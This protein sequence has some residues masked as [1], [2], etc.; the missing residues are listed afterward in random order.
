[1]PTALTVGLLAGIVTALAAYGLGWS[2][3][4]GGPAVAGIRHLV[5]YA[6]GIGLLVAALAGPIDEWADLSLAGHMVQ[7]H[8]LVVAPAFLLL[9]RPFPVLVW[10]LPA[11][12]RGPLGRTMAKGGRLRAAAGALSPAV[13]WAA[14]MFF[15]VAWHDPRAYD[16][17]VRSPLVHFFQHFTFVAGA[18]L[19][20][21][22]ATRAAPRVHPA[23]GKGTRALYIMSLGPISA[24]VGMFLAFAPEPVYPSYVVSAAANGLDPLADQMLGGAIMWVMGDMALVAGLV[25]L[26]LD[27]AREGKADR[28]EPVLAHA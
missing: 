23:L 10:G 7:H 27:L 16:A 17:S 18:A 12:L 21:W 4:R 3:L 9:A 6:V 19:F 28:G 8:L 15:I 5:C 25:A 24:L 1:V 13:A 14:L 26:G 20:W 11:P 2:R 22:H